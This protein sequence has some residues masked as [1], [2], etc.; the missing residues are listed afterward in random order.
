MDRIKEDFEE[1]CEKKKEELGKFSPVMPTGMSKPD[2]V[3]VQY[4]A[5]EKVVLQTATVS[6]V[7]SL[8]KVP[9]TVIQVPQPFPYQYNKRVPWNYGMKVISTW[10]G[11]PKTKEEVAGN[12]ASGLGGITRSGR[13]YTPEE[14]ERRRKEIGKAVEEPAKTKAAEDEAADFLRIIKSSENT[15]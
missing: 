4:A 5:K 2:P 14:L 1:F 12:L 7:Q 13:C 15:Q 8:E 6:V 9:S 3:V 11:K 10:E